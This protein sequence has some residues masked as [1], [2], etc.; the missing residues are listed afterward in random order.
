MTE[1]QQQAEDFLTKTGTTFNAEFHKFGLH[2]EGD[3]HKRNI[4][5]IT[6]KND[7]HE[8]K[9]KF[10]SSLFDSL[11]NTDDVIYETT[12]DFFYGLKYAGLK[13]EYL[14]YRDTLSIATVKA[15]YNTGI[16]TLVDKAK[17][18]TIYNN[19]IAANTNKYVKATNI[20]SLRDWLDKLES[21]MIRKATELK[22]K[23][24]GEGIQA[25]TIIAPDA[26]SVLTGLTKYNPGTFENFCGD[27]GYDED[28]RKGEKIYHAVV[29]EWAN[30]SK[31]FTDEQL[32]LLQE[33]N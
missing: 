26:Y 5:L 23:N 16:R 8:Y 28:S 13:V 21:A 18:Q 9:F 25:D 22:L 6:L 20:I 30:V 3:Q 29:E 27:F 14:S 15:K 31:L 1:Y 17:A 24:F 19:F 12:I 11:K 10:G 7:K 2:F 32:E 4:F 33:I